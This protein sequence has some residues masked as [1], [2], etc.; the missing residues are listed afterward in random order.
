MGDACKMCYA[1][2]P[3]PR[4]CSF[5]GV[6]RR[7]DQS[8]NDPCIDDIQGMHALP[9]V[10]QQADFLVVAAALTPSTQGMLGEQ[11]L[12]M[13]K[14]GQVLINVGR[15]KLIDESALAAILSSAAAAAAAVDSASATASSNNGINGSRSS[16][17][18]SSG[19]GLQYASLDV[20][21]TEP[22]Q[23][24]SPLWDLP[25]VFVSSHNADMTAEF[26]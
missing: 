25:N 7:P 24:D 17:A 4:S 13:C 26:R 11:E 16:G 19:K 15:G 6:R 20:F 10:L 21:C 8:R 2:T 22:L 5:L 3:T 1:D 23:G 14:D 9:Q 18:A 12:R